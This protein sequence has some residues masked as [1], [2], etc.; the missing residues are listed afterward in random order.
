[1]HV[2][3]LMIFAIVKVEG[4]KSKREEVVVVVGKGELM[5]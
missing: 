3:N 2:M 5:K 1:M 4:M